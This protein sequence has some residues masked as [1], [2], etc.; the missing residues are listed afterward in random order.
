MQKE[1]TRGFYESKLDEVLGYVQ[2]NLDKDLNVKLLAERSNISFFHFHR[3][4]KACL[5]EPLGSYINRIRLDTAARLLRCS[6]ENISTIGYNIGYSDTSSFSKSFVREFGIT[7][8]DYRNMKDSKINS[9]IDFQFRCDKVEKHTI[10]TRIKIV[11]IRTVAYIRVIGR[12]GGTECEK[13]WN[14]LS[15]F[16][17]RN[18]L[19]R[20]NNEFFSIYHDDPDVVG[21]NNCTIDCCMTI[22]KPIV[23]EGPIQFKK[24]DGGRYMIFRYKGP[25]DNLWDVYDSIYCDIISKLN[26]YKIKDSPVIEKYV[27]Y[28][29]KTLPEN[30]V[31][32]IHIP[33]Q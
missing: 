6:D 17:L 1:E 9:Q 8:T 16:A 2:N 27:K 4:M 7:P 23:P 21:I 11:T 30:L 14:L 24:V 12:Y 22:K 5:G 26:Q 19:F 20:W 13:A 32:E 15:D 31:T 29:E 33:V 28:S 10:D 18:K 3:I 25:Y